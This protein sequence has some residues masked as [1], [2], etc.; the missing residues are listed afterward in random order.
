VPAPTRDQITGLILAGGRGLRMGGLDKGWI[1]LR[2]RPLV[3]HVLQRFAPQVG[4]LLIS[5]NRSLERYRALGVEVVV[6]D[7]GRFGEFA[8]PL[9]G[10]LQAMKAARTPWLAVA[11]CDAPSVPLDL[12]ARLAE[13]AGDARACAAW[14]G[15][16]IQPVFCL[17]R[18]DLRAELEDALACGMR[19]PADFLETVGAVPVP[20]EDDQGFANLNTQ[21]D[22]PAG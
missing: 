4:T 9:A 20:F 16:R 22:L 6:D 21:A 17:L 14:C 3:Q 12:V 10:M 19:K 11:P 2:G 13:A 18:T 1:E 15:D 5:A 8:G 7:A